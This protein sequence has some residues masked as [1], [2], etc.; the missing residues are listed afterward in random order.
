M[1]GALNTGATLIRGQ[2]S[3]GQHTVHAKESGASRR[4]HTRDTER[5]LCSLQ[6]NVVKCYNATHAYHPWCM[7]LAIHGACVGAMHTREGTVSLRVPCV[8]PVCPLPNKFI[9][10][11]SFVYPMNLKCLW[12][13]M[14]GSYCESVSLYMCGRTWCQGARMWVY[15]HHPPFAVV[16]CTLQSN[17]CCAACCILFKNANFVARVVPCHYCL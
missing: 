12:L 4:R 17:P 3:R 8:S 16:V 7:M 6:N 11:V 2:S 5:I 14:Q 13:S 10:C 1:G 9:S 15:L